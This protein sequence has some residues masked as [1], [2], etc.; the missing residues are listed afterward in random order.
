MREDIISERREAGWSIENTA[1]P[2]IWE[3]LESRAHE[4]Y[5]R[6]VESYTVRASLFQRR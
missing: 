5:A 6:T 3:S 4:A 1:L 2:D